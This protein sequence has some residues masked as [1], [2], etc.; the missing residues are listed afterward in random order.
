MPN[1]DGNGPKNGIGRGF[2]PC[3]KG[4][5]FRGCSGRD[6]GGRFREPITLTKEEEEKILEA[7][8]K[9]IELE[10]KAIEKRLKEL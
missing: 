2:G 4:L 9:E 6:F 10:K 3:G 7:E 5:A 1:L 8:L